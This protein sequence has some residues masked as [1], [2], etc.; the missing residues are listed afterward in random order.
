MGPALRT[1]AILA[2]NAALTR[3]SPALKLRLV[4]ALAH[5]VIN[6]PV[7]ILVGLGVL[8]LGYALLET[9][10]RRSGRP[11]RIP[12]GD[13]LVG[14]TFWIV[15]EHGYDANYVRNLM[16]DPH[17]RVKVRCGLR[18]TWRDGVAVVLP[19]DDPHTRQRLLGSRHPLRALNA[20]VVRVMGTELLTI[21][22]D[23]VPKSTA[24]A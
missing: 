21:R 2:A 18:P 20:A 14:D 5:Y 17:V 6:P 16:R 8:P 4:R 3:F 23:L 13:G 10:G 9:T 12:V 22:I 1:S 19:D 7:R 11:R 15:A 24:A